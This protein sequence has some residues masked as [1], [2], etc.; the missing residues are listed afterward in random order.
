MTQK[1][2][3]QQRYAQ[4][5]PERHYARIAVYRR[6]EEGLMPKARTLACADCA[7]PA[8]EY[9]HFLGYDKDHWYDVEPVC[10]RC[11]LNR[12]MNRRTHCH[13]GHEYTDA[14]WKVV[15]GFKRRK[16]WDCTR[17]YS[18][19]RPLAVQEGAPTGERHHNAKLTEAAVREIR[20][21]PKRMPQAKLRE[22]YGV[23]RSAIVAIRMGK[24]WRSVA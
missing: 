9:D 1:S 24:T 13:R 2:G 4:R 6:T 7:K 5:Y 20:A 17:L 8:R 21:W 15:E 23:S 14:S 12:E 19:T 22:K 18:R 10:R 11:H 16:C 3:R